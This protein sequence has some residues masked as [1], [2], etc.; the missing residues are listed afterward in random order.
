MFQVNVHYKKYTLVYN[1]YAV[2]KSRTMLL[3]KSSDQHKNAKVK[4]DAV[5]LKKDFSNQDNTFSTNTPLIYA[6]YFVYS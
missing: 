6:Q 3:C 4:S 1:L 5:Y 2:C